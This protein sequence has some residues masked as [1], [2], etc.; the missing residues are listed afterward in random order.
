M[1]IVTYFDTSTWDK[2][3]V[4]WLRQAKSA[5]LEGFVLGKDLSVEATNKVKELGFRHIP[6]VHI[7][8]KYQAL[9]SNIN[10]GKILFINPEVFPKENIFGYDK[11]VICEK[12]QVSIGELV[13][14]ICSLRDRAKTIKI[15]RKNADRLVSARF[16]LGTW[17]F[18]VGFS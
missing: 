4:N 14:P 16:V 15:F 12:T 11:D 3:G 7:A 8:D 10:S 6:Y 13:S 2:L 5:K 9:V 1:I 17:E 18:W